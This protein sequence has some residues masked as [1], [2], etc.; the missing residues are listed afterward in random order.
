MSNTVL[1]LIGLA[2]LIVIMVLIFKKVCPVYVA[3]L[4]M[5]AIVPFFLG[6]GFKDLSAWFKDGLTAQANLLGIVICC[7]PFFFI[8]NE[9]GAYDGIIGFIVRKMGSKP[10]LVM[11]AGWLVATLGAISANSTAA[12]LIT[13][14]AILPLYR[15]TKIRPGY[16]ATQLA[17]IM[18]P[19]GLVPW[20]SPNMF[21]SSLLGVDGPGIFVSS[22]LVWVFVFGYFFGF[23]TT[24]ILGTFEIRRINAGKNDYLLEGVENVSQAKE[25]QLTERQKKMRPVN[26]ILILVLISA[27]LLGWVNYL[28]AAFILTA[29]LL[30]LNYP[31]SAE[32]GKI[33]TK[34]APMVMGLMASFVAVG[35]FQQMFKGT[36]MMGAI[37]QLLIDIVP[38]GLM[39]YLGYI[40]ACIY[41]PGDF[42]LCNTLATGMMPIIAN[43]IVSAGVCSMNAAHALMMTCANC[44]VLCCISS[45]FQYLLLDMTGVDL[46]EHV[47]QTLPLVSL[48]S[49]AQ[50]TF[51]LVL[52]YAFL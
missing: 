42:F 47:K 17:V 31:T 29:V 14:P 27:F 35:V 16:L 24:Q 15:R 22:G 13:V 41:T 52:G 37:T 9:L 32:M 34:C 4:M 2:T 8:E 39:K 21:R 6:Y 38:A 30:L 18:G 28:P 10:R 36:G 5:L 12:I 26:L 49:I 50:A 23:L 33:F 48:Q 20:G 46:K 51:L 3:F 19:M 45:A 7:V 25:R 44:G 40:F 11:I 1:A 43:T